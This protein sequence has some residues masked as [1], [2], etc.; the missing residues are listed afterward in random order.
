MLSVDLS[1][2]PVKLI[3]VKPVQSSAVHAVPD[4]A[5]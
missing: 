1:T 3:V 2:I 5:V 4:P